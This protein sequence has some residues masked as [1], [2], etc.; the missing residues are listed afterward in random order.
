[1]QSKTLNSEVVSGT[2]LH[3]HDDKW[4]NPS[5]VWCKRKAT[6]NIWPMS[7]IF[8]GFLFYFCTTIDGLLNYLLMSTLLWHHFRSHSRPVC[9]ISREKCR[10]YISATHVVRFFPAWIFVTFPVKPLYNLYFY[11]LP[12]CICLSVYILCY[13]TTTKQNNKMFVRF[14][15]FILCA[16]EC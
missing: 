1:M 11:I 7:D 3:T 8:C 6:E 9:K 10:P 5:V 4:S 2:R 15:I 12:I 14:H 16:F 13:R